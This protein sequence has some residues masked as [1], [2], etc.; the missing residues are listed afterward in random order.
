[1]ITYLESNHK[2]KIITTD[3]TYLCSITIYLDQQSYFESQRR[4][5]INSATSIQ[6]SK[7][8]INK[9]SI[10]FIIIN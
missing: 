1:M 10:E 3:H 5:Q 9:L 8:Q 2:M 7:L 6:M 4:K